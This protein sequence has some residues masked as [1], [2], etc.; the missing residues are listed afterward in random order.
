MLADAV[1]R[2]GEA[3]ELEALLSAKAHASPM[4]KD[5][6][7]VVLVFHDEEADEARQR[8]HV[9][10]VEH[11]AAA[12]K[13]HTAG[14]EPS[15]FAA[16]GAV[17]LA[18]G[19]LFAVVYMLPPLLTVEEGSKFVWRPR[20]TGDFELD[21]R[22]LVRYRDEHAWQLLLGMAV[23]YIILQTFCVPASGT[24]MNVLAGCIF[25]E[26]L[27]SG[28]YLI[29][30]PMAI[31]CVSF[32]AVMCYLISYISLRELITVCPHPRCSALALSC[33]QA[34]C[35]PPSSG[36]LLPQGGNARFL[37]EPPHPLNRNAPFFAGTA[38]VPSQGPVDQ[39]ENGRSEAAE[40]GAL[41]CVA[42]RVAGGSGV[43]P[44]PGRAGHAATAGSFLAG[45]HP[46]LLAACRR[47][48]HSR[49]VPPQSTCGGIH[50]PHNV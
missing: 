2:Q 6:A 19:F 26:T 33:P 46:G 10:G 11:M 15:R 30:L 14:A 25:S 45:D 35:G 17:V 13:G 21:K 18:F 1:P 24:S 12:R 3:V 22:V 39:V 28:E 42:S 48:C 27:P 36:S 23:V 41:L 16:C 50:V 38:A 43:P 37:R 4:A 29:A 49:S 47:Y 32:G 44:Q 31:L 8:L 5:G 7:E 40:H 20:S 9:D 34:R